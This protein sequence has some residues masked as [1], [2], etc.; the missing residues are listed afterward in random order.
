M[1]FLQILLLMMGL[2]KTA[3]RNIKIVLKNIMH[4]PNQILQYLLIHNHKRVIRM[5]SNIPNIKEKGMAIEKRLIVVSQ[6]DH[7]LPIQ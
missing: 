4:M 3:Q 6:I 1:T 2:K 7:L 5:Q